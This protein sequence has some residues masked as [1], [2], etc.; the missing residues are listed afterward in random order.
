[1][2]ETG[3]GLVRL[4][5][6]AVAKWSADWELRSKAAGSTPGHASNFSTLDSKKSTWH[7][8]SS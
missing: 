1:M 8:K 4:L 7:P 3:S 5:G 2:N 6:V